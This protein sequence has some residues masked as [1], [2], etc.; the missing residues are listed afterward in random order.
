[1]SALIIV[2]VQN[3]FLDG[4]SLQVPNSLSILPNIKKIIPLFDHVIFSKDWHPEDHSSFISNGGKWPTHCVQNTFGANIHKKIYDIK[5]KVFLKGTDKNH[6]S[7]SAFYNI[8][9]TKETGLREYLNANSI[10]DLY[11]CGLVTEI[12]VNASV[13]D[14][15]KFNYNCNLVTDCVK[16][17]DKNKSKITIDN[18]QKLGCIITESLDLL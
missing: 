13:L 16:E 1:M 9:N 14:G 11:F 3:D 5:Y 7:Y 18:L 2:D 4:G 6:D 12:C 8:P 17:L 15:L 10:K